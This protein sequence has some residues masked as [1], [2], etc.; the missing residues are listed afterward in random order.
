VYVAENV[1]AAIRV[2]KSRSVPSA[3]PG[4]GDRRA[5]EQDRG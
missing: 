1:A 2:A 4:T 3:K 5:M